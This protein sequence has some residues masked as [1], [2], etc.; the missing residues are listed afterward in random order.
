MG[1]RFRCDHQNDV[2]NVGR[3]W[4]ECTKTIRPLKQVFPVTPG[5]DDA[6]LTLSRPPDY[7]VP[8]DQAADVRPHKTPENPPGVITLKCFNVQLLAI[9]S[10]DQ[11]FLLGTQLTGFGLSL[12][13]F[14]FPG[15]PGGTL[16]L[17]FLN[18]PLLAFVQFAFGHLVS[19]V[20]GK[21][22]DT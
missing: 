21:W 13:S 12:H 6:G 4:L 19:S 17:D 7:P 10:N 5:H 22:C 8:G 11:P 3:Y 18:P 14:L 9:M 1:L 2:V 20:P 16:F 15:H